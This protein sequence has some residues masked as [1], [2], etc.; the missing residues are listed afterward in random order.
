VFVCCVRV[1]DFVLCV[2]VDV[3]CS[4]DAY[5][6]THTPHTYTTRIH[7]WSTYIM[8]EGL[9]DLK[10]A[11]DL[12]AGL[13]GGPPRLSA[14]DW[15]VIEVGR[16]VLNLFM[17]AQVKLEGEKYVTGSLVIPMVRYSLNTERLAERE[18]LLYRLGSELNRIV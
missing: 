13:P 2:C 16:E 17:L 3:E 8:C 11:I 12:I 1:R 7:R 4:C 15:W 14:L 5:V 6:Y 18:T 10:D 9:L